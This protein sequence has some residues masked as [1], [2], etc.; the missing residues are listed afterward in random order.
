MGNRAMRKI[1]VPAVNMR[2]KVVVV[3]GATSGLGFASA[4]YLA[5]LNDA[6]LVMA[7]REYDESHLNTHTYINF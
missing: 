5:L 1:S 6:R 2:D 3:T 7:V 4:R